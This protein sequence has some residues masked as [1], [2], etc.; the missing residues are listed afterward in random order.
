MHC[1]TCVIKVEVVNR[2]GD[3]EMT[4]DEFEV[5][6]ERKMECNENMV[7]SISFHPFMLLL[8]YLN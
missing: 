3:A 4:L 8:T 2:R 5:K 7:S 1:T 6:K